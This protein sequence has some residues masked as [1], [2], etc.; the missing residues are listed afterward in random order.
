MVEL[1]DSE[2]ATEEW[3]EHGS[4]NLWRGEVVEPGSTCPAWEGNDDE[5]KSIEELAE[6]LARIVL[7]GPNAQT[8]EAVQLA[9]TILREL[10]IPPWF[11]PKRA[12]REEELV[13]VE[14]ACPS[15]GERRIDW[16][17][18]IDDE[19]VECQTCKTI[20]KP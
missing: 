3:A 13:E 14:N 17:V 19:S 10:S 16:L 15:C 11:E 2:E 20:Y 4:L 12:G 9:E 7:T 5:A 6:A 1:L 8:G 18:W